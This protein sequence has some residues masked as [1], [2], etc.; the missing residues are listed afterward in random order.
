MKRAS[1][2]AARSVRMTSISSSAC[3]AG[4]WL[5]RLVAVPTEQI[6]DAGDAP[7]AEAMAADEHTAAVRAIAA[8]L[9]NQEIPDPK[10]SGKLSEA[11]FDW[12]LACTP[13]MLRSIV[14]AEDRALRDHIRG[15][16]SIRG[17]LVNDEET[18]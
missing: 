13:S 9:L 4:Q 2:R 12:L 17:V 6:P 15:K 14:A 10:L 3:V 8:H 5:T 7:A 16:K 18:D 1:S 11:D